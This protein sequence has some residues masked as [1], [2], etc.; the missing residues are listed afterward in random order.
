MSNNGQCHDLRHHN[1]HILNGI[2]IVDLHADV[3]PLF[4][5]YFFT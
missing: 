5:H 4:E 3:L 2:K 1:V